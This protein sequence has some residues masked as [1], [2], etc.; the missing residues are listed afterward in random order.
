[1]AIRLAPTRRFQLEFEAEGCHTVARYRGPYVVPFLRTDRPGF[2]WFKHSAFSPGFWMRSLTYQIKRK[3]YSRTELQNQNKSPLVGLPI[4]ILL[5]IIGH[6]DMISKLCIRRVCTRL[7]ASLTLI[8]EKAVYEWP[9]TIARPPGYLLDHS[10]QVQYILMLRRDKR[11]QLRIT[12]QSPVPPATRKFSELEGRI[13]FFDYTSFSSKC[14]YNALRDFHHLTIHVTPNEFDATYGWEH[15]KLPLPRGSTPTLRLCKNK[16]SIDNVHVLLRRVANTPLT[17]DM[18]S[19]ALDTLNAKICPHLTTRS[20]RLFDGRKLSADCTLEPYVQARFNQEKNS[21]P[22]CQDP[23]EPMAK[24]LRKGVCMSYA[25]C[26]EEDC[27]TRYGM[28]RVRHRSGRLEK[29][30]IVVLE[31][32]RDLFE[33]PNHPSWLAHVEQDGLLEGKGSHGC[34]SSWGCRSGYCVG[35]YEGLVPL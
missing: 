7:R 10:D 2:T 32:C 33:G 20:P 22:P 28:R 25:G 9:K 4:E 17:H 13:T 35:T 34:D 1:M 3:K 19:S 5:E 31:V 23:D 21:F 30:E 18:L 26:E 24:C 12:Y 8:E 11:S 27:E 15:G 14:L 29:Y 16:V 6:T